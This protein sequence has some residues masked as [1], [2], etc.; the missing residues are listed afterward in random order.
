MGHGKESPVKEE[1]TAAGQ[2]NGFAE[3]THKN[4][5]ISHGEIKQDNIGAFAGRRG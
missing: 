1:A 4:N 2:R 5:N 3:R